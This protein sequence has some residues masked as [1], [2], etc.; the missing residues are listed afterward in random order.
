LRCGGKRIPT[1]CFGA[2]VKVRR[3]LP[4][5]ERSLQQVPLWKVTSALPTKL[6]PGFV[7]GVFFLLRPGAE[8]S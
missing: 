3:I 2:V 8:Q 7:P 4:G 5:R 1:Y 6:T